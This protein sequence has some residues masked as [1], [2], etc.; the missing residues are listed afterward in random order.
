[1]THCNVYSAPVRVPCPGMMMRRTENGYAVVRLHYTADPDKGDEWVSR[2]RPK[3]SPAWWDQEMEINAH[4]RSGQ[5]VYP[6]FDA[7]IHVLPDDRIP[8][9]LCRWMAID[10]HPRTPHA[11]LWIG[12]DRWSD[13]YVYR[14]L[15]PSK[16]YGKPISLKDDEEDESYA[17]RD[18]AETI[19]Y[20]EGNRIEWDRAETDGERGRYL[21]G[22]VR[23][24]GRGERFVDL[25]RSEKIIARYMDQAGKGF[26]ASSEGQAEEFYSNRYLRYGVPCLDPIKSHQSGE[27]AIRL[28]LRP[29]HHDVYGNWPKLHIASSCPELQ[30]EFRR[31]R[32][33]LTK[34]FTEERELKQQGVEARS[35]LLDLLRYLATARLQYIERLAS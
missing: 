8:Q 27:D 4:A 18:Y 12:I 17:I 13:W 16:V 29:R 14:E 21:P 19:A 31:Y 1:M 15:W 30:L 7:T 23:L 24:N 35:H 5:L 2:E 3:F 25:V 11:F 6:E 28:L 33:K 9:R 34:R 32:Y 20:L 22:K 26:R 10:P